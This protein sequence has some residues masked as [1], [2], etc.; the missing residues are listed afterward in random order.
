MRVVVRRV[1]R[2]Y[3]GHRAHEDQIMT[4][5]VEARPLAEE[6]QLSLQDL[7]RA[8]HDLAAHGYLEYLGASPRV[9]LT[10]KAVDHVRSGAHQRRSIRD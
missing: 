4:E 6:S 2:G 1:G 8:V 5:E 7:F 9:R 10:Q 3:R